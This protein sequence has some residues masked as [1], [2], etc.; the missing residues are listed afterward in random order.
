MKSHILGMPRIG[1]RREL[2]FALESFW[3]GT[4]T[5]QGLQQVARNLRAEN[6]RRQRD[7]G[8]D[9][10][11]V[12]DF[13]LYDHVL[14]NFL[15]YAGP[16]SLEDQF[17][18]ARGDSQS[19]P[20]DMTK[21]FDTNYHYLVP[22][23]GTTWSGSGEDL[24]AEVTEAV[25]DGYPADRLKVVL[26]GPVTLLALSHASSGSVWDSLPA[27]ISAWERILA[28]LADAGVGWVQVDEPVLALDADPRIDEALRQVY[29]SGA[30]SP[31]LLLTTYFGAVAHQRG[32]ID[33]LCVDGVHLDLVR[34]AGQLDGWVW[35]QGRVLS[36]GILDGRNVWKAGDDQVAQRLAGVPAQADLW[37]SSSCSLLH[38]PVDA[39][40]E[41]ALAPD[42]RQRL[43]FAVQKLDEVKLWSD[44]L[45]RGDLPVV[46]PVP[47]R[48]AA[49]ASSRRRVPGFAIRQPLQQAALHLPPWPTTTIGSF[50]Q[51]AEIRQLRSAWKRGAL[52]AAAYQARLKEVT[53]EALHWQDEA[54][55]D[56]LVHGE[57]ERTDMVEA[58]G[59]L[60]D[61]YAFTGLGWVQSYGS[62]CVKPPLIH[63]DVARPRPMTV[64]WATFAQGLT[65][66]PVKG[67]LTGPVTMLQWAFVRDDKPRAEIAFQIA[68]AL[69]DEVLDLEAAGLKVIQVDEPAFREGL[70]LR[71]ED[72]AAYWA[73]AVEAFHRTVSSVKP[74]TQIH[75]HM[76]YSDF[77]DCLDQIAALD[78]DVLTIETSRSAMTLLNHF[79][80]FRYPNALGPGIWDIHSPRIPSRDEMV[81]LLRAAARVVDPSRLW[82]NPDCGLK[83]RDWPEVK[84]AITNLVEAARIL[85]Q[86]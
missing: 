7:A 78:A 47:P 63:A 64:D 67:M 24:L 32:L 59:E 30:R 49:L 72:Q 81:D 10:I 57:F 69:R 62:R 6:R 83:T 60:L 74:E 86:G 77:S 42:L 70:P 39:S 4:L 84:T 50:P 85:R 76:C 27:L 38:V 17:R 40:P 3:K 5:E 35:P 45:A 26:L 53:A 52:D 23:L 51:T 25:A 43:S 82:V 34:G 48:N 14:T 61:G 80:D 31:R 22:E 19:R 16:L 56:V 20:W 9:W 46:P 55:L 29:R 44:R 54:G 68:D 12:G 65:D 73:W 41:T 28:R 2:K 11:T 21:W 18:R 66:K 33:S 15:R 36:L 79:R 1:A 58:F 8:L 37:V 71:R 75:T 13:A